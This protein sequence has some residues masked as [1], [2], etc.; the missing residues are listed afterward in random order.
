MLGATGNVTQF[1]FP[2]LRSGTPEDA[3]KMKTEDMNCQVQER[4]SFKGKE[5]GRQDGWY[6][7]T[8]CWSG[9]ASEIE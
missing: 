2:N 6:Q 8:R 9:K 4:S 5:V 3:L 7:R 1:I